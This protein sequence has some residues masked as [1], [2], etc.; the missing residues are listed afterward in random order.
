MAFPIMTLVF[1]IPPPVAR[2]FSYM[3]QSVGMTAAAFTIL[4][5]KVQVEWKSII[6]CT[7]GNAPHKAWRCARDMVVCIC[8]CVCG[9]GGWGGG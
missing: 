7:I 8:V 1:G 6:Y 4:W 2:D 9:G 5:M 3:I